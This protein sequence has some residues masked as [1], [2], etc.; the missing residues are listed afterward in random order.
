MNEHLADLFRKISKIILV[1]L[2]LFWIGESF[3]IYQWATKHSY[4]PST[5]WM[6]ILSISFLMVLFYFI[7]FKTKSQ[8]LIK[9]YLSAGSVLV[10]VLLTEGAI[11]ILMYQEKVEP[12]YRP[13][14]LKVDMRYILNPMWNNMSTLKPN[15]RGR[16]HGHSVYIN[17]Y[18]FR[19]E[20]FTLT[21]KKDVF[22][23]IVLG[24]SLTY[25]EGVADGELYTSV[26]KNKLQNKYPDRKIEV[27]NL[28]ISGYSSVDE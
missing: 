3:N 10:L 28:G 1:V 13:A 14:H 16:T 25:G 15:Y 5:H 6:F 20:E 4:I 2:C 11:R 19:S 9:I 23:I 17:A 12:F 8:T 26:L 22:R 18:G 27:V 21:K 7:A 24:D